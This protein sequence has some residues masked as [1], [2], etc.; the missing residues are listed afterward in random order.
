VADVS[1]VPV[2]VIVP[3][4]NEARRLPRSL[5]TLLAALRRIP[6][7]ELIVVDDGSSDDTAAIATEL[8]R[9]VPDGQVV[10]LPWNSGKGVA[11]RT[12]VAVARGEAIVFMDADLSSDVGDLPLL[13][14]ALEHAEVALGSRRLGRVVE[15]SVSRRLGSWAFNHLT[16]ALADLDLADTQCGFKAFRRDEAKILFSLARADGFGFDVE[17]LAIARAAGYRIVEVPVRWSEEPGGT[18]RVVRHTPAMVA[19]VARARR[20]AQRAQVGTRAG[21]GERTPRPS[22][23]DGHTGLAP[24]R[25]AGERRGDELAAR[26]RQAA[27]D[28]AGA[29]ARVAP[30]AGPAATWNETSAD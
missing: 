26:P 21:P 3:A 20:Y 5:P 10:R 16:R 19:E 25:E 6:G 1:R 9:G 7:A 27:G 12:G 4:F 14:T 8:L 15:R 13:L 28:G 11:V 18:F 29:A 2:S 17:V 24:G 22:A 30:P 23:Y